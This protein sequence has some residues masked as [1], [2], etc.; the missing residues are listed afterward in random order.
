[1]GFLARI[2]RRGW[3]LG[4]TFLALGVAVQLLLSWAMQ[5]YSTACVVSTCV[6]CGRVVRESDGMINTRE[7]LSGLHWFRLTTK[8]VIEPGDPSCAHKW[9]EK[10]WL[11]QVLRAPVVY[12]MA[13]FASVIFFFFGVSIA[14]ATCYFAFER[15]TRGSHG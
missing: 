1:M 6:V 4:A 9:Q 12:P 7:S 2:A 15:R 3:L 5:P 11:L 10:G 14:S 8:R 13:L